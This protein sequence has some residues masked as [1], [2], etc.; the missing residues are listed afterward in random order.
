[1]LGSVCGASNFESVRSFTV[2]PECVL[3]N[4]APTAS[5]SVEPSRC[6]F[7]QRGRKLAAAP[8]SG[9][10]RGEGTESVVKRLTSGIVAGAS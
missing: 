9:G 4:D 7:L 5:S 6:S 1:M 8:P 3:K 10:E 2:Q